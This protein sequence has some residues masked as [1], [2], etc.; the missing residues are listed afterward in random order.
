MMNVTATASGGLGSYGVYNTSSSPSIRNS[1][2]TGFTSI[3]NDGVGTT[4]VV[5]YTML[6]GATTGTGFTCIGT[7]DEL[8]MSS[9]C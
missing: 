4:A 6:N 7:Y 2:I 8:F 9:G 3:L 1:S 5:A